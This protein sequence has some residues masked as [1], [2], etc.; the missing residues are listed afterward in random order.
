MVGNGLREHSEHETAWRGSVVHRGW[1]GD[2]W[3]GSQR[4]VL[5]DVAVGA[6]LEV[7]SMGKRGVRRGGKE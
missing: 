4:L 2:R 7:C 5:W 3:S 1:T 6:A